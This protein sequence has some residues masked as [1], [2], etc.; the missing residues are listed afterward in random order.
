MTAQ[1]QLFVYLKVNWNEENVCIKP[2]EDDDYFAVEVGAQ[3]LTHFRA[4]KGHT[5]K[6]L[7]YD[8]VHLPFMPAFSALWRNLKVLTLVKQ[9]KHSV[10]E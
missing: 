9:T 8:Q 6:T 3:F 5:S 7:H 2:D 1:E 10:L 4:E